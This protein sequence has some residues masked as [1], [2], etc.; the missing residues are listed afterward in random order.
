ME[1]NDSYLL[2]E[3]VDYLIPK[4]LDAQ[5]P[6]LKAAEHIPVAYEGGAGAETINQ[7]M[8][9]YAGRAQITSAPGKNPPLVGILPNGLNTSV[10][11]SVQMAFEINFQESRAAQRMG[12]NVS[13]KKGMAAR[14]MVEREGNRLA[15]LGDVPSGI[16]GLFTFPLLPKVISPI[17]FNDLTVNPALLLDYM[18]LWTNLLYNEITNQVVQPNAVLMP[19]HVKTRLKTTYKSEYSDIS[20]MK[21]WRDSNEFI[22]YVDDVPEANEA[23][24]GETPGMLFYRRDPEYVTWYVPQP[25]EILIDQE[26]ETSKTLLVHQRNAGSFYHRMSGLLVE[27]L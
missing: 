13:D 20:L 25:T 24:F 4:I 11:R 8:I 5:Y 17:R 7:L 27:G 3:S 26:S 2:Q 1:R 22:D 23:G 10:V 19:T 9:E 21:L 16:Y 12:V 15:Y 18:N 6:K 14:E